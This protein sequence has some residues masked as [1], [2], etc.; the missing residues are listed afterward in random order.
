[1]SSSWDGWKAE[2]ITIQKIATAALKEGKR[3]G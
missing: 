2:C 1:V 3:H